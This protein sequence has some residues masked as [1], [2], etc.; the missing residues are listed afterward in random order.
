M[1]NLKENFKG[2]GAA[3]NTANV[4]AG[5]TI[6]IFGLGTVGLAVSLDIS[7]EFIRI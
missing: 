4:E 5:S 7:Y 2:I 1:L 6:A 3:W